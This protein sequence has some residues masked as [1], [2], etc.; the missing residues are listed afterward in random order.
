MLSFNLTFCKRL[1][2]SEIIHR[3]AERYGSSLLDDSTDKE[4]YVMDDG[5]EDEVRQTI[6][7]QT[8]PSLLS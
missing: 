2:L 6:A 8:L 4:V 3:R 5:G 7:Y 1:L